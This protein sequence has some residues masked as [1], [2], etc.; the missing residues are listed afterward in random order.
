M[1]PILY[2]KPCSSCCEKCRI[3]PQ[4]ETEKRASHFSQLLLVIG[5]KMYKIYTHDF[6]QQKKTT[7]KKIG[8]KIFFFQNV[9]RQVLPCTICTVSSPVNS[10]RTRTTTWP[11]S[12]KPN[13]TPPCRE[14]KIRH[15]KDLCFR[16]LYIYNIFPDRRA[17]LKLFSESAKFFS[18]RS[19]LCNIL[20]RK[21]LPRKFLLLVDVN[22]LIKC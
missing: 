17:V 7:G 13:W 15:L 2:L 8:C 19:N 12:L 22:L 11:P 6:Y 10:K 1:I 21:L 14:W 16:A 18:A 9:F 3:G 20:N 4:A 5:L